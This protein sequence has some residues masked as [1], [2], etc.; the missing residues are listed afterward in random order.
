MIALEFSVFLQKFYLPDN[1]GGI[2][3]YKAKKK[4]PMFFFDNALDEG[5][6]ENI[7]CPSD[8]TYEKWVTGTRKPDSAVW[9]ELVHNFNEIKLQKAL[10]ASLSDTNLRKV[11]ESFDIVFEMDENPDKLLFVKAVVEQ[12][13]AIANCGGSAENIVPTE[14]KKPPEIKGFGAYIREAKR[15]FGAMKLPG[16]G[17]SPLGEYFVCNHI[18]TSSAAFPNRVRGTYIEN[19]TLPVLRNFDRRGET[20]NIILIGACG[21]GKTLM[22]QHLF[23]EAANHVRV[24][25]LLPLFAE[26][27]NYLSEKGD[28]VDFLVETAQEFDRSFSRERWR[29]CLKEVRQRSCLMGLMRW[30]R[31]KQTSFS[32][33]WEN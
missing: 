12:F 32:V 2:S 24:T 9:A 18:G 7:I 21:Y 4:V 5:Y 8:S 6:D 20:R 33:G 31:K 14:Y 27:R 1:G 10:L 3:N 29:I 25:G 28:L 19:A 30:I 23:L 11:M 15:K 22:L 16:E 13:K 17:E 26:L